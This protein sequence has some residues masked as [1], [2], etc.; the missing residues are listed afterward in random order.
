MQV[1]SRAPSERDEHEYASALLAQS[2]KRKNEYVMSFDQNTE[3]TLRRK[4]VGV[5]G[6][7]GTGKTTMLERLIPSLCARGLRVAAVKHASHGF[8][9]DRPGKDSYRLYESGAEAVALISHEQL[10]TFTRTQTPTEG[11]VSLD[12][13][14]ASLPQD[15]DLVIAEG[16]SWESIP[17]IVLVQG[18]ASPAKGHLADGEVLQIVSVP[19]S[20]PNEKPAY[21]DELIQR[22]TELLLDK[23]VCV[24]GGAVPKACRKESRS[25]FNA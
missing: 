15:L 18:E 21:S 25:R 8:L 24:G 14:L 17:R 3:C 20:E 10:A 22:L 11:E 6:L 5:V 19:S 2:L 13:A 4:V 7:S 23:I 1:F 16:F 12:Q 9:A